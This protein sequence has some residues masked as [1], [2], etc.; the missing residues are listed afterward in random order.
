MDSTFDGFRCLDCAERVDD[1][2]AGTCPA[3]DGALVG[4][5]DAATVDRGERDDM[6]RFASRLPFDAATALT[7]GEGGTP[8]VD[9]PAIA[10]ELGVA[11]VRVKDDGRNPTGS[12]HDR[13]ASVALTAAAHRN[14]DAVALSSPGASG[15]AVAAYAARADI[16][17]H[18]FVPSRTP[19]AHKAM[20][21][22]HGGDMQVVGGRYDDAAEACAERLSDTDWLAVGPD[23]V[24]H[25]VEGATTVAYETVAA[26]DG[27]PDAVV[28]PVGHGVALAGWRRG[29]ERLADSG[30]IDRVPRLYAVQPA[31]CA[32]VADAWAADETAPIVADTPDTLCGELEIPDPA[33]GERALA[34]LDA[35]DGGAV[36]VSDDDLL[37]SGVGLAATEGLSVGL[38]GA[39]AV[40]GAWR[41]VADGVFAPDDRVVVYNPTAATAEADVLRS[42]LMGQGV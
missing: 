25:W 2:T 36:T 20:I 39:T 24:P 32:P 41:L 34:A 29:L 13:G 17:S 16:D 7:L 42:H 40:A 27:G 35:T 1:P 30:R 14:G 9:C 12:G 6:W 5:Y 11:S 8:L 19:F 4:S 18:A 22:V 21:N 10:D 37:E 15:V 31:G 38:A 3:C 33:A 23:A 28:C 26:L